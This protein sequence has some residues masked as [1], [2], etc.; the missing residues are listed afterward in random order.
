[1][2][3]TRSFLGF[4]LLGLCVSACGASDPSP[5]DLD[6]AIGPTDATIVDAGPV[7]DS[8]PGADAGGRD[9]A[10]ADAGI[11]WCTVG[12]CDPREGSACDTGVCVP[13]PTGTA[14]IAGTAELDEGDACEEPGD[15][16]P[17]LVCFRRGDGGVCALPCCPG[18]DA[19]VCGAEMRCAGA[20]T[21]VD[22]TSTD[23]WQCVPPRPCDPLHPEAACE[24]GEGCY[25]VS[26]TGETDCRRAGEAGV[27]DACED[28][29]DCAPGLFCGGL[30][31]PTCVRICS[32]GDA[33][34]AV[35]CPSEEGSCRAYGHS[36]EGTGICTV[37]T[38]TAR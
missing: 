7:L 10:S 26:S 28:Q 27:G 12:D 3:W 18:D 1:M 14:C 20:G 34:A 6:G 33:G 8:G 13:T 9:A 15:C 29:N 11:S 31:S 37:E 32:L 35:T 5:P 38:A 30:V 4:A 24:P 25:I 16:L 17:G 23:W 36:P 22:G 19:D 21:R 2:K